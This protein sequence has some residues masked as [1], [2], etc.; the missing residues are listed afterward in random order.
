[1]FGN[2][3]Y[4][5]EQTPFRYV[6]DFGPSGEHNSSVVSLGFL[7]LLLFKER[8]LR[9]HRVGKKRLGCKQIMQTFKHHLELH[10]RTQL[11]GST[12]I[13]CYKFI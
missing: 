3:T 1:M 7:A 2:R 5:P 9:T 12:T 4:S 13:T 11:W 10:Q 6:D 8:K